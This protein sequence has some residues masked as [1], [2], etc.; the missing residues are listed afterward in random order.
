MRPISA[1][2]LCNCGVTW[3]TCNRHATHKAAL[4]K[5]KGSRTDVASK[6][7]KRLLIDAPLGQILDDDLRR[8]SKRAKTLMFDNYITF[9]DTALKPKCCNAWHDTAQA[10][11][12]I[13]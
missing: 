3:H 11:G 8:E 12:E 4:S 10:E 2:W 13:S 5:A 7:S 9:G 6:A 1:R